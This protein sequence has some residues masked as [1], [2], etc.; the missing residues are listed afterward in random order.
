M[1]AEVQKKGFRVVLRGSGLTIFPPEKNLPAYTAHY[2]ER[3]F[4]PV[5]RW[6][7]NVCGVTV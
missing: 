3:A 6:L 1:I 5:R 7:K 2:G 4:H